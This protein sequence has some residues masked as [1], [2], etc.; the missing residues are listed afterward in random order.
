MCISVP[1]RLAACLLA[2]ALFSSLHAWAGS[3]DQ[4]HAVPLDVTVVATGGYWRSEDDSGNFRLVVRSRG[5]EHLSTLVLVERVGSKGIAGT[6][7]VDEL[8][9]SAMFVVSNALAVDTPGDVSEFELTLRRRYEPGTRQVRIRM[10]SA[11]RYEIVG[12][13]PPAK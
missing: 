9:D 5:H 7:V 12:G 11:G 4:Q 1:G 6:V 3:S 13:W 8:S 10:H 2:T